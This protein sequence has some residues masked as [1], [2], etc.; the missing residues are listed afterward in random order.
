[1]NLGFLNLS[2]LVTAC[3]FG[4]VHRRVG[5]VHQVVDHCPVVQVTGVDPP[6]ARDADARRRTPWNRGDLLPQPLGERLCFTG[7][8]HLGDQEL[9][10][11]DPSDDGAPS[12]GVAKPVGDRDKDPVAG[13]MPLVSLTCLKR[14]RSIMIN[15]R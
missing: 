12:R 1:M 10:T 13:G 5:G 8:R 4:L 9:L 15:V 7:L 2:R 14:S 3:A 11:T 6:D